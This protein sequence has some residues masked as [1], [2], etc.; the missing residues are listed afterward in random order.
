MKIIG[1]ED[2]YSLLHHQNRD[3][4]ENH[5]LGL[6]SNCIGNYHL[7]YVEVGFHN[8][9]G[10]D[11]CQVNVLP[12]S[13]PAFLNNKGRQEFHVRIG[14]TSRPFNISEASEYIQKKWG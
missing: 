11:L 10:K 4:F 9:L 7:S 8:V 3:G 2:D 13:K 5:L 6:I 12:C 1:I 14:N